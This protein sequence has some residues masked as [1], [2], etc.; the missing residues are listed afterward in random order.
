MGLIEIKNVRKSYGSLNAVDNVS[1]NI[2]EGEI[3]GLLGPNGAGKSTL[4]SILCTL[5]PPD[6]GEILVNNHDLKKS[7][8]EIKKVLGLVPQEIA[9]YPT[10]TARENLMFWG[11]MYGVGGKLLRERVDEALEM[12]GLKDRAKEVIESYSGGMKRRINIAAALLHHPKIVIMD[13]PTVGI[14][15]QSR[16]H[17]L[18][19]VIK[20]NKEGM[21]VI[22]TSHYMEEVEFLCSRIAIMDHGKVIASGSKEDLQ[23]L[24]GSNDT[25]NISMTN[26]KASVEGELRKIEGVMNLTMVDGNLS[27]AV[28]SV[29]A[30]LAKIIST[31]DAHKCKIQTIDIKQPNLESVFL[32]LTGRALRD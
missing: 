1:L 6:S 32:H 27:I 24:V 7:S 16:N 28:Q 17:I 21:T 29:D 10:L 31:L 3:F 13:E 26:M 25:I 20:L 15:P 4:I 19:T 2:N 14:D 23:K 5:L 9:L 22:Y 30:V 8:A 12:A 11:R 18:E